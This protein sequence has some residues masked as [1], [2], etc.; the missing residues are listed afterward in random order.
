MTVTN[1]VAFRLLGL[2]IADVV[3]S[4]AVAQAAS[5]VV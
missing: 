5:A 1:T 3:F 2:F 4:L